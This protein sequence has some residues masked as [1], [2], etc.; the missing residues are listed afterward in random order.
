M[1]SIKIKHNLYDI[2]FLLFIGIIYIFSIAKDPALGDSLAFTLQGY[3][4][5]DFS[6]NA[7]NHLLF[8]NLLSLLHK[9]FPFIKIHFL[10]VSVSI[11]SA[12]LSL[13]YLRKLLIILEV[14]SKSS[15]ICI[16]ILG[17]S[18]TFWRQA[19]ITEVY[20]FYLLF[21]ILFLI[22]LFKF[23][24]R[25]EIKY[26][27]Y[28]SVLLGILFLIHIQTILFLFLYF[29]FIF[30]NF[31]ILKKHIIYGGLISILLFSVLLIPVFM[32][33]QTFI[34]IFTDN[35][36][37][38]S[39]FN[40]DPSIIFKS[41]VRNIV[42]FIYNFLFFSVFLFWGLKNKTYGDYILVGIIPFLIFCIKHN[43][44]DSYVFQL[45][46]YIFLL[47]I[48]GRGLDHFPKI[49]IILPL[50][51]PLIYFASYK[52]IQKTSLGKNF[53]KEKYYKGGIR[54]MM[55]P[56]LKGNPDWDYFIQKYKE[57]SLYNNPDIQYLDPAI[58][59][60]DKIRNKN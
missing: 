26:F 23:N 15:F 12:I 42:F 13:L 49:Y 37:E 56:P 10:F 6:S 1:N 38:S 22:N 29:Y 21:V 32:G 7:T 44:S 31:S 8:S 46:P 55:F 14:S 59:E 39:L 51:L 35:S 20:T 2:I 4:G 25:K 16:M 30:R 19:I 60:W 52:V 9:I 18:F 33:H 11:L 58:K 36:Y 5:F 53:E 41:I 28:L 34:A 47:I 24:Q 17:L 50:F 57:D 3:K 40:F 45:V 48:I 43:V 54:Y 27:Y